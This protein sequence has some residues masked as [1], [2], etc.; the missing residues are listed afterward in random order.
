[1]ASE[2]RIVPG[3]RSAEEMYAELALALAGTGVEI[4]LDEPS[5]RTR[6]A[7]ETAV[8]VAVVGA[9][10]AAFTALITG[11]LKL[12]EKRREQKVV[13]RGKDGASVEF[14]AGL[15]PAEQQRLVELARSLDRPQ[16][17]IVP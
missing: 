8:L 11:L 16:I 13:V 2:I 1:M 15:P 4:R 7:L 5:A 17:E 6:F 3:N 12:L 10:S 9:S 14:P